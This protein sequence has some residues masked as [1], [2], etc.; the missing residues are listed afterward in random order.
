MLHKGEHLAD[1]RHC[2]FLRTE[3]ATSNKLAQ[4]LIIGEDGFHSIELRE[5]YFPVTS[6]STDALVCK[7]CY[8]VMNSAKTAGVGATETYVPMLTQTTEFTCGPASLLMALDYFDC[9]KCDPAAEELEIWR[10]ATTIYMTSGHGGC[11]PYG[12]SPG[13]VT[14]SGLTVVL[15]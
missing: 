9:P 10:E 2:L 11:G 3:I 12:L 15:R 13:S 7:N 1:E 4:E 5:A 6:Q 8:H 14:K